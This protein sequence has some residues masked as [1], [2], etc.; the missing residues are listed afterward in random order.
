M[1]IKNLQAANIYNHNIQAIFWAA[2]AS[3]PCGCQAI[4][5]GPNDAQAVLRNTVPNSN[6]VVNKFATM[7]W[8]WYAR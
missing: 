2:N 1:T 6:G 5:R 3:V 7:I 4:I 8:M